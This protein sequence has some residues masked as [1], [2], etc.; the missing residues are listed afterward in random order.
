MNSRT[1]A[2]YPNKESAERAAFRAFAERMGQE[3]EWVSVESRQTPEPDLLCVSTIRG[4]VAFE[5]V[6]IT[7]PKIAEVSAGF[8]KPGETYFYTSD[9]SER[10]IRSKLKKT[11]T[12]AH[13]IELLVYT[14]RLV[15]TP[16]DVIIPTILPWIG[17]INHPFKSVWFM[18]ERET[19]RLWHDA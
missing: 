17:S 11:Y 8:A 9:P 4:I 10:I 16:D 2:E 6:S 7:D 13:R 19:L 12:S 14:D 15:I 3:S 5:L 18:G 1:V